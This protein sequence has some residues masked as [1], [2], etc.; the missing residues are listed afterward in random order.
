MIRG[1]YG[2]MGNLPTRMEQYAK[3]KS[4]SMT[5]PAYALY[6]LDEICMQNSVEYL[7]QIS[8]RVT[9]KTSTKGKKQAASK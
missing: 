6:L 9:T 7:V 8:V 3:E 1:Y 5:G 4:L 2:E